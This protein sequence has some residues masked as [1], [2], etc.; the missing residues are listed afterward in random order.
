MHSSEKLWPK[1]DWGNFAPCIL[2]CKAEPKEISIL[3]QDTFSNISRIYQSV[4]YNCLPGRLDQVNYAVSEKLRCHA[5]EECTN[6]R[7]DG[8]WKVEHSSGEL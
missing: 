6:E 1:P 3:E 8:K 2:P 7:T 4:M 5:C